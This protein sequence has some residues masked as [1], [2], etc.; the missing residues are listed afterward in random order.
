MLL[1]IGGTILTVIGLTFTITSPL[2]TRIDN[3]T[4]AITRMEENGKA[5]ALNQ[6]ALERRLNRIENDLY[7]LQNRSSANGTVRQ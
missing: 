5:V 7:T 3:L 1:Q 6:T 4:Q 2:F